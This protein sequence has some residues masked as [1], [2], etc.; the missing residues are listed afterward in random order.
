MTQIWWGNFIL[1]QAVCHGQARKGLSVRLLRTCAAKQ[2]T[3]TG[4]RAEPAQLNA[5][6]KRRTLKLG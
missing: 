1:T 2:D 4:D 5:A 3:A 6:L